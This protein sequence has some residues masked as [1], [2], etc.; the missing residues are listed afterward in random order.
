MIVGEV[1]SKKL[2]TVSKIGLLEKGSGHY[3][4]INPSG[5]LPVV[6][7]HRSCWELSLRAIF[8][9]L[10]WVKA[11]RPA[12]AKSRPLKPRQNEGFR[13]HDSAIRW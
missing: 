8:G 12:Q 7:R 6:D 11:P 5:T 2:I 4:G 10:L 13:L 3:G 1:M 9:E